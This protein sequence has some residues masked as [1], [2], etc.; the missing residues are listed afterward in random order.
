VTGFYE[1]LLAKLIVWDTNREYAIER[2]LR[3][4]R[5]MRVVGVATTIPFA[6]FAL[7]NN[8][9]RKGNLSTAFVPEEFSTSVQE[10]L[11]QKV[12]NQL[13]QPFADVQAVLEEFSLRRKLVTP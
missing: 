10:E 12:K 9:F 3:A 2:M 5:E 8:R 4:L 7:E 11:Y 1:S 6:I 13:A